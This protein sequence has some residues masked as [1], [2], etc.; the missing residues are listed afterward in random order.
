MGL[1]TTAAAAAASRRQITVHDQPYMISD[2]V[3]AAPRRGVYVAGN[4]SNDNGLP[5]GFLVEQPAGAATQPHFHIHPQFQLVIDGSGAL[6]KHALSPLSLHYV[7]GHTPYGPVSAGADGLLYFT[8]R[9]YWDPGAKYMPA[10]KDKLLKGNQRTRVG[11]VAPATTV[12]LRDLDAVVTTE[13]IA[14]ED[15]GLAAWLMQAG[16]GMVFGT[17]PAPSGDGQ[18]HIVVAGE[19]RSQNST[20]ER[21]SCGFIEA[22]AEPPLYQ[23]S[24][25]GAAMMI[26]QFPRAG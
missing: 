9:R 19:V 23:A 10:S 4:E 7:N 8:L 22:A 15:D 24:A 11:D 25:E 12:C 3:G 18:Y 6:G 16:P 1:L 2:Y 13:V 14:V 5:Q 20:L 21:L 26:C 17:P